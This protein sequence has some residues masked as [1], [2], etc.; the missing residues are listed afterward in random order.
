MRKLAH[1]AVRPTQLVEIKQFKTEPEGN[2][3]AILFFKK[4][5]ADP[6]LDWP[7]PGIFRGIQSFQ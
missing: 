5:S 3:I 2:Q 6:T 1:F 4:E 7:R